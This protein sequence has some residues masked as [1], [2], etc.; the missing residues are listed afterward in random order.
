MFVIFYTIHKNS[1]QKS[2]PVKL[3]AKIESSIDVS[4]VLIIFTN[5]P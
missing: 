3:C 2:S 4:N 1:I 5:F